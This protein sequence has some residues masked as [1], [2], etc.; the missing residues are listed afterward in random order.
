MGIE[1]QFAGLAVRAE[2][3]PAFARDGRGKGYLSD[4]RRFEMLERD[5]EYDLA[6]RWRE[7]GDRDAANHLVTSHLRLAAK[8]AMGYRVTV[9]P[10]RKSSP[11]AMLA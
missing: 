2:R 4:I 3:Q 1:G 9:C 8:I 10:S 6:K 11:K 5:R 7:Y